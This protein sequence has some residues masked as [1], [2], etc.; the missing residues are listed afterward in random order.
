MSQFFSSVAACA[1]ESAVRSIALAA[2][3]GFALAVA[4]IRH[5][6]FRLLTW[7]GVLY[8]AMLMPLLWIALPAINLRLLPPANT[9]V[10]PAM[11]ARLLPNGD[12]TQT[13][14]GVTT[15]TPNAGSLVEPARLNRLMKALGPGG[16]GR[17]ADGGASATQVETL[18]GD[19]TLS[20]GRATGAHSA[21][22]SIMAT[23]GRLGWWGPAA[24]AYLLVG[25]VLLARVITGLVLGRR[26]Q[27]QALEIADPEVRRLIGQLCGAPNSRSR[28]YGGRRPSARVRVAESSSVSIPLA[29]GAFSPM[30]L[31]PSDWRE[32]DSRK[33]SAVLAHELSHVA[34]R[35]AVTQMVSAVH[36][37][38]FWFSPLA[39]W[40][41]RRLV[42]LA[43][44]ASDDSA[45]LAVK[46]PAYYAEVLLGFFQSLNGVPARWLGV[47]MAHGSR[48]GRRIDRMLSG[49][50]P[51]TSRLTGRAIAAIAILAIGLTI[52]AASLRIGRASGG[53]QTPPVVP[54]DAKAP[55]SQAPASQA[56]PAAVLAASAPGSQALPAV[57]APDAPVMA[58]PPAVPAL[59]GSAPSATFAPFAAVM[60]APGAAPVMALPPSAPALAVPPAAAAVVGSRPFAAI[61][62]S[63]PVI[64]LPPV[65]QE[66]VTRTDDG[67][68]ESF[69]IVRGNGSTSMT[70]SWTNDEWEELRAY[71]S[72]YKGDFIWF[73]HNGRAYIM[74]DPDTIKA[75]LSFFSQPEAVEQL[76]A[77]LSKQQ[78]ALSE[79]QAELS[80][81]MAAIRIE[82]PDSTADINKLLEHMKGVKAQEEISGLQRELS[83]LQ[84][85]ISAVQSQASQEQS[86]LSVLQSELSRQQAELS[87]QQAH[88]S[89]EESRRVNVASNKVRQLLKRALQDGLAH[90][91]H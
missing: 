60:A 6:R 87:R 54:A 65:A 77:E 81:Q 76:Q 21:P 12:A 70:G 58:V 14:G 15:T 24:M 20:K 36:R 43:E 59:A 61:V 39:W 19:E 42:D 33:L 40:L 68:F 85:R 51:S 29:T 52:P 49:A 37:A 79:K 41:H 80:Q 63:A 25:L 4:R 62:P 83:V 56:P 64:A 46:D 11:N 45:L 35:D 9:P 31:L 55:R 67:R 78:A 84:S 66:R 2:A 7:T 17:I 16:S 3:A 23:G 57:V 1:G 50:A 69:A 82:M 26:L 38:I 86:K 73:K 10:L 5:P 89:Q 22:A 53:Q 75:A 72:K 32:W 90:P 47:S 28:P 88:V 91:E 30:I 18:V 13:A 27:Q 74:T 71:R 44:H 8:T 34:R 48:A